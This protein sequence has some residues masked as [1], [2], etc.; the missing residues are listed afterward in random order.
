[1]TCRRKIEAFVDGKELITESKAGQQLDLELG[2]VR[3]EDPDYRSTAK[4]HTPARRKTSELH[5][6]LVG[7]DDENLLPAR[8]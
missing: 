2:K 6:L 7:Q 8:K 1:L 4:R 3:C 5:P